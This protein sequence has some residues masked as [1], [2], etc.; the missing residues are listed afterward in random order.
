MSG[1]SPSPTPIRD[2]FNPRQHLMRVN[3]AEYLKVEHRLAWL[4]AEHPD[5]V[6][7]TEMIEWSSGHAIFR[8]SVTLPTGGRATGYG[9][10]TAEDFRDHIEKA[11]TKAIGRALAALG[12]GT[13]FASDHED[14]A[15]RRPGDAPVAMRRADRPRANDRRRTDG[16][17]PMS[18]RQQQYLEQVAHAAGLDLN[19]LDDL[20][21]KNCGVRYQEL[22]RTAASS[23]ITYL[24]SRPAP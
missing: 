11:E 2:A 1:Q 21:K 16:P 5:A 20:A 17:E 3:G 8:A 4:R 22:P 7:E 6:L 15:P 9:S 23:L 19:A 14:G 24:Q 18:P 10:E 13:Q 12:F